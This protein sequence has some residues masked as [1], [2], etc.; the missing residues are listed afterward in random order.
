MLDESNV[1]ILFW[2]PN[3]PKDSWANVGI[4]Y[5]QGEGGVPRGHREERMQRQ[6]PAGFPQSH[7]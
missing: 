3:L 2:T 4:M 7:S 5:L 1:N 6:R